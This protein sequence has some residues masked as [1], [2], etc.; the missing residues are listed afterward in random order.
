MECNW[1]AAVPNDQQS[2]SPRKH[3]SSETNVLIR[4][5]QRTADVLGFRRPLLRNPRTQPRPLLH[6]MAINSN[7]P[8]WNASHRPNGVKIEFVQQQ[9]TSPPSAKK[10]RKCIRGHPGCKLDT[11]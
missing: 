9:Y 10:R 8:R 11:T 4:G 5:T 3:L 7:G 1:S 6:P 2:D